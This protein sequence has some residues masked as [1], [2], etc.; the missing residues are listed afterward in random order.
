MVEYSDMLA[1]ARNGH[2]EVDYAGFAGDRAGAAWIVELPET[3]VPVGYAVLTP[4]DLPLET[5]AND[6]ELRRIYTLSKFHGGGLGR[7]LIGHVSD[8]ARE[9]GFNRLLIGVN[10]EN[11]PAIGFYR[12]MGA[13][14]VG[15][16]RFQVGEA[17][18]DDLIL[19]IAL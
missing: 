7:A 16:R 1:F 15:T 3:R 19:G 10:A 5:R 8:H 17:L 13:E 18:F 12:R 9:R 4:P 2:S 6:I 11:D 14:Q